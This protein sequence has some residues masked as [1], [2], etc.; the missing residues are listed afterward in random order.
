[1]ITPGSS[2]VLIIPGG[3]LH[4]IDAVQAAMSSLGAIVTFHG[5]LKLMDYP[6]SLKS[7]RYECQNLLK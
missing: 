1:M 6:Q 4:R 5:N 7:E 3:V 2:Q